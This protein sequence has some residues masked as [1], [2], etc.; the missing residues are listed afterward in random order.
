MKR[1]KVDIDKE[2]KIGK[3]FKKSFFEEYYHL[4]GSN[5]NV[6]FAFSNKLINMYKYILVIPKSN[7]TIVYINPLIA[8]LEGPKI[9]KINARRAAV[10]VYLINHNRN[11]KEASSDYQA[12]AAIENIYYYGDLYETPH[13]MALY[14]CSR[15]GRPIAVYSK[16]LP[17]IHPLIGTTLPDHT[18]TGRGGN[19]H[20]GTAAF[21]GV[22]EINNK[23]LQD[24]LYFQ[25][26]MRELIKEDGTFKK[27]YYDKRDEM[28][29]W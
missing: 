4:V 10:K 19:V 15:C 26:K 14:T 21:Y 29:W 1:Y 7:T 11:Y 6:R 27:S 12:M 23:T 18:K 3:T 5:P 16:P 9:I 25:N 28:S 8:D 2:Y 20:E 24:A 17:N 13:K 22:Q